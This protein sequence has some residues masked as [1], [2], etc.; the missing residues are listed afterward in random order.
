VN[1]CCFGEN[2]VAPPGE[3]DELGSWPDRDEDALYLLQIFTQPVQDG[4]KVFFGG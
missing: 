3:L 2:H 4:R 1:S